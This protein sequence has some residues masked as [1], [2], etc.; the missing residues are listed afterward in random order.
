MSIDKA[1]TVKGYLFLTEFE[2]VMGNESE[3]QLM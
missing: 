2:V 1:V 3:M